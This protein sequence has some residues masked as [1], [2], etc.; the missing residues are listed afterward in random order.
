M[1]PYSYQTASHPIDGKSALLYATRGNHLKLLVQQ[2]SSPWTEA[3]LELGDLTS[4]SDIVTH[5]CFGDINGQILLATYDVAKS[6]RLYRV[7]I[8]WNHVQGDVHHGQPPSVSPVLRV[9]HV[10]LLDRVLPQI[11]NG[12]E[13]SQL[14]IQPPM[15]GAEKGHVS[16]TALFTC[17]PDDQQVGHRAS[18]RGSVISTWELRQTEVVLHDVFK[19]LKPGTDKPSASKVSREDGPYHDDAETDHPQARDT[20]HCL[21][22]IHT[23]KVYLSISENIYH[24]TLACAASDGTI[25]FRARETMD[26]ILADG[27]SSR[28]SSLPQAGFVFIPS[29]CVDISLSPSGCIAAVT[30]QDGS[31]HLHPPAFVHGWANARIDHYLPQAAIVALARETG[32]LLCHSLG[33]DDILALLP[34]ELDQGL[35][36]RFIAE[37]LR[38]LSKNTDFSAEDAAKDKTRVMKDSLLF[39]VMAMQLVL[40]YDSDP[41]KCDIPAKLAWA[42]LQLRSLSSNLGSS[43]QMNMNQ[44][45]TGEFQLF[46]RV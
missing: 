13:L 38:T 2:P 9:T 41:T 28:V 42:M 34:L 3:V 31:V 6:L 29:E 10:Q 11:L 15:V 1:Q 5:A 14:L 19:T 22:D 12:A 32:I 25:D 37:S 35:R 36:R 16:L 44:H 26:I 40:G 17:L 27:D 24:S 7:H 39:K 33:T 8:V 20:L 30:H 21:P 46:K 4:S 45:T 23:V 43:M 18:G